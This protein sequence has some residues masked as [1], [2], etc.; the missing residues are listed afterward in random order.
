MPVASQMPATLTDAS[1]KNTGKR[2]QRLRENKQKWRCSSFS[3][4]CRYDACNIAAKMI[5]TGRYKVTGQIFYTSDFNSFA[6]VPQ[7]GQTE[8]SPKYKEK[9]V[10]EMQRSRSSVFTPVTGSAFYEAGFY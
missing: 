6:F 7:N 8:K 3:A 9:T 1:E 10:R 5:M 2:R 4:A